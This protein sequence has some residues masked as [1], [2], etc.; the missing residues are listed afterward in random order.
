MASGVGPKDWARTVLERPETAS[1]AVRLPAQPPPPG[2]PGASA[3][4]GNNNALGFKKLPEEGLPG[5]NRR[6]NNTLAQI[7]NNL[8]RKQK[9]PL[10][11]VVSGKNANAARSVARNAKSYADQGSLDSIFNSMGIFNT[12]PKLTSADPDEQERLNQVRQE[13]ERAAYTSPEF[14]EGAIKLA[15]IR[16]IISGRIQYKENIYGIFDKVIG[17]RYALPNNNKLLSQKEEFEKVLKLIAEHD[18]DSFDFHYRGGLRKLIF[19]MF[20]S[21]LLTGIVAGFV[22][23]I[24]ITKSQET[25]KNAQRN[26]R[27]FNKEHGDFDFDSERHKISVYGYDRESIKWKEVDSYEITLHGDDN[28]IE[29]I[30]TVF[31]N[32]R[33]L[34]DENPYISMYIAYNGQAYSFQKFF[35]TFTPENMSSTA[36]KDIAISVAENAPK[37]LDLETRIE[38][39]ELAIGA[40]IIGSISGSLLVPLL[41]KLIVV[42]FRSSN[43]KQLII[44]VLIKLL[45]NYIRSNELIFR[46]LGSESIQNI[47]LLYNDPDSLAIYYKYVNE[48]K[49]LGIYSFKKPVEPPVSMA[50]FM[51]GEKCAICQK[52]L[53][54][55]FMETTEVCIGHHKFHTLCISIYYKGNEKKISCPVCRQ[56]I[57]PF[58]RKIIKEYTPLD[59]PAGGSRKTR[60]YRIRKSKTKK[61]RK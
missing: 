26:L 36:A 56:P 42:Y 39:A 37:L 46:A 24:F 59:L 32:M 49:K 17:P 3:E 10:T 61:H 45:D 34:E 12:I 51:S 55:P 18:I 7:F 28:D 33:N 50:N 30:N 6:G 22:S 1:L 43:D 20:A 23:G 5:Q 31:R 48:M 44:D 29:L 13:Q 52:K 8:G 41:I 60:K 54:T 2:P 16:L 15:F 57:L 11:K 9:A 4:P 58:A 40:A 21:F 53:A 14:Q 27:L 47:P 35:E 19:D 25:L 38:I